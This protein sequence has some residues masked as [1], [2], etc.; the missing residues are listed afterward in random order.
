MHA[1]VPLFKEEDAVLIG[2]TADQVGADLCTSRRSVLQQ[3]RFLL[4]LLLEG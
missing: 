4:P 3:T 1:H 2:L